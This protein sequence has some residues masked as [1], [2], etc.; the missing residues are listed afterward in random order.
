MIDIRNFD[1]NLL[2]IDKKSNKSIDIYY[3]GQITIKKVDD[4]ENIY[5]ANPLYLIF[6]TANGYIEGKNGS[7]SLI[8]ALQTRTKKH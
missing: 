5:S 3:T 8:F 7:K 4:Y 1:S 6:N 2:Q